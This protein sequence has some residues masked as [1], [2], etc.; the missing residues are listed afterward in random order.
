MWYTKNEAI[1]ST[2]VIF[3]F[4]RTIQFLRG[5]GKAIICNLLIK[6]IR[7]NKLLRSLN[8]RHIVITQHFNCLRKMWMSNYYKNSDSSRNCF[9]FWVKAIFDCRR[10]ME[11]LCWSIIIVH[12]GWSGDLYELAVLFW[13]PS[14]DLAPSTHSWRGWDRLIHTIVLPKDDGPKYAARYHN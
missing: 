7:C 14:D 6:I 3:L 13:P 9:Y 4:Y 12:H 5:G 10:G 8:R 1:E 11:S 2:N